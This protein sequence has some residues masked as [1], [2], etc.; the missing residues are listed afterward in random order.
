MAGNNYVIGRGKLYWDQFLT[1]TQTPTG[2]RYLGNTPALSMTSA[3]Q[4]LDHYSSDF[5]LRVK[6]EYQ[7]GKHR[8]DVRGHGAVV[9]PSR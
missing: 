5:G 9:E 2:Q 7:H 3:Y 8:P 4:N 1:G 6:D